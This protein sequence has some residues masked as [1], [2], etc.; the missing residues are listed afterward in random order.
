MYAPFLVSTWDYHHSGNALYF[1]PIAKVGFDTLARVQRLRRPP[2]SFPAQ[3][4]EVRQTP[5]NRC[6][7]WMVLYNFYSFGARVG[8]FGLY[9]TGNKSPEL[10]SYLD[11]NFGSV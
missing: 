5:C 4:A 9:Q 3:T 8:H 1:G 11:M 6:N 7:S 2:L 10:L